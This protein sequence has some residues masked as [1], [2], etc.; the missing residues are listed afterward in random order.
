MTGKENWIRPE[1]LGFILERA[2]DTPGE[3]ERIEVR[4][5]KR[6]RGEGSAAQFSQGH[7]RSQSGLF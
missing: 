6:G 5:E 3:E 1:L 4:E 2:K 7:L